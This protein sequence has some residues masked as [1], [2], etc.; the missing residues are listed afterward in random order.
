MAK[1]LLK[2][3]GRALALALGLLAGAAC[4]EDLPTLG[5]SGEA[6]PPA[7]GWVS[8]CQS[9]ARD[10]P[11]ECR[12]EQRAVIKQTGQLLAQVTVR[13][14]ADTRKPVLMIRVPLGLS[15]EAG[16][17]IDV[18]GGRGG[19]LPLQTC[20][21]GGCYAGA[22]LRADLLAAMQ[23]GEKLDVVFQNLEKAPIKLALPLAGFAAAF[24]KVQ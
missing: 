18:D 14:P 9:T 22:P 8:I 4:A 6:P 10:A 20:D 3:G 16:V 2:T 11:L 24:A 5:G 19:T 13:I 12:V 21:A 23:K 1:R 17:T 15:L 7:P